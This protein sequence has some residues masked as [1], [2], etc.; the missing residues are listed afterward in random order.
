M[1]AMSDLVTEIQDLTLNGYEAEDIALMC[2]VPVSWVFEA[3]ALCEDV[4]GQIAQ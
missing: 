2:E 4:D 3:L 1:S